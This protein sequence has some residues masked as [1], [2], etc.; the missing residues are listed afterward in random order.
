MANSFDGQG[1]ILSVVGPLATTPDSLKLLTQ[2]L[3]STSPWLHDPLVHEIPWRP[4]AELAISDPHT[5]AET[6]LSF[7]V[8]SH[9][10]SCAVHPPVARA[11]K[12]VVDALRA[13]GHTVIEWKPT[14]TH[15]H[16][17]DIAGQVYSFDGG[18]DSRHHFGLSG[19]K[20]AP[21]LIAPENSEYSATDIMKTNI[22]KREAQKDYLEYWNS[23]AELTGTG[24]PVDAI[25]SP[26]APFAA[27][28]PEKYTYLTYSSYVNVLDYTSVVVPVTQ[29][30]KNVDKKDE[31]FKA[32]DEVDQ[33]TQDT[34]ECCLTWREICARLTK[35]NRRPRDLRRRSRERA[36]GRPQTAGREDDRSGQVCWRGSPR[37]SARVVRRMP[38]LCSEICMLLPSNVDMI[39]TCIATERQVPRNA[40]L[41]R[42]TFMLMPSSPTRFRNCNAAESKE[43]FV[44]LVSYH[45]ERTST[46]IPQ[47]FDISQAYLQETCTQETLIPDISRHVRANVIGLRHNL[48]PSFDRREK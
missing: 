34:C 21:Q 40:S 29:V 47:S 20:P 37:E 23:T 32:V 10:G 3:L 11:L 8:L 13:K 17:A 27:A 12:M 2:A 33:E 28:R 15:A 43:H 30:D 26:L 19:E 48:S 7:A 39:Q 14:P 36:A 25:I 41:D 38:L 45:I 24:R 35:C 6:P 9:D 46:M 16:L 42:E 18:A 4:T 1:S 44:T 31:N 5:R 22:A